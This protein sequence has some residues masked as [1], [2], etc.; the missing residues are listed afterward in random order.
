M[1][2]TQVNIS[3]LK[4]A[5][6]N[7]RKLTG[8]QYQ[9]IRTSLE[10][11]GLVDPI[12]VNI[13]P[14]RK[15]TIIGGHQRVRIWKDMGN[16]AVPCVF[17]NLPLEKE[18]ELNVRLNKNLGDWDWEL[19]LEEFQKDELLD[20]GFEEIDFNSELES[21]PDETQGDDVV[22]DLSDAP[23]SEMGDLYELGPHRLLC[24][25]STKSSDVEKLLNRQ[26]PS[27]MITDPPYG[28]EY[29]PE[30]REGC[31]LGVGK[32]SKGKVQ[33]DNRIDWTEAYSLFPGDICYVWHAGKYT[34]LIAQN[35][36]DCGFEIV[37]QIIWAKQHFALSRG[38]Y[39]WQHE[40]CWYAVRK[41]KKHQWQGKRDQ[42][43]LWE[44]KNNNSFG[45]SNKEKTWGHGT[46]KPILCMQIPILNNSK[47]GQIIYD[48]FSGSG[49]TLI[50]CEKNQRSCLTMELDPRYCDVIVKRYID[51]CKSNQRE[52]VV[53]RNGKTCSNFE[54]QK[55]SQ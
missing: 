15:N 13:N 22:P 29:D 47:K 54:T 43:T 45:N 18:R 27:L 41:G 30:W 14:D 35:I 55:V 4:F 1:K 36:Q 46:Q 51:F 33:N 23:I 17:L 21:E 32:R 31:D 8:V 25:D 3:E 24:G 42:T 2:I 28:V 20:W 39:H 11:F 5:E 40:P 9:H 34:H 10:S 38:D 19:L 26:T 48:P 53:K 37:S 49:T 6:Y 7:P 50:A 52:F 44:I 12:I 16:T